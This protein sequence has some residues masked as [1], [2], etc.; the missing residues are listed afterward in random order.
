M[1]G[2]LLW[3][4]GTVPVLPAPSRPAYN[5]ALFLSVS[6]HFCE[7]FPRFRDVTV[8]PETVKRRANIRAVPKHPPHL[9]IQRAKAFVDDTGRKV[10]TECDSC[11]EEKYIVEGQTV[12]DECR[13]R[14]EYI[15]SL[16]RLLTQLT[17]TSCAVPPTPVFRHLARGVSLA[18][19]SR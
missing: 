17:P 14:G 13:A 7:C 3:C 18:P 4:L 19:G 12:C 11:G 15:S 10:L 16:S 1:G 9:K 2:A 8:R 6:L 5:L